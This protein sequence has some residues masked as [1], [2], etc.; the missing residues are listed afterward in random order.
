MAETPSVLTVRG[1]SKEARARLKRQA[2]RE[3]SSVNALVVRLIEAQTGVSQPAR[4]EKV[5]DLSAFAGSWSS[6]EAKAFERA[7]APFGA[8]DPALWK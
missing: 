3:K 6:A 7:T 4:A 5:R 8:I 2:A 1:V